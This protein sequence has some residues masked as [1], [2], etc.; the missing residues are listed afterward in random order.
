M[1]IVNSSQSARPRNRS[2]GDPVPFRQ[3]SPL[4]MACHSPVEQLLQGE[5]RR[6]QKALVIMTYLQTAAEY[7][8]EVDIADVAAIVCDLIDEALYKLDLAGLGD[9]SRKSY[10]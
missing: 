8:I 6:L 2:G 5:N 4:R 3:V 9:G 1:A 7:E 10:A